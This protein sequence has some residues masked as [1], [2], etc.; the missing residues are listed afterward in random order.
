MVLGGIEF[1][2]ISVKIDIFRGW[3]YYEV[4][5]VLYLDLFN[6]DCFYKNCYNFSGLK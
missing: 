3:W 4:F 6:F 1:V 2:D 5:F